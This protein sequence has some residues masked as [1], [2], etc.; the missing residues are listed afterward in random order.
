M[1][2]TLLLALCALAVL[3]GAL[4]VFP[5]ASRADL[6]IM[7]L[8][9]VFND[10]DRTFDMTLA[11]S[12]DKTNTYRIEWSFNKMREDGTYE[13]LETPLN[14]EFDFTKNVV[15]SPRQVTIAPS[16]RQS[17]RLSLR[18]PAELPEGEYRAHLTFRRLADSGRNNRKPDQGVAIAIGVNIGFSVPVIVRVG[19][20]DAQASISDI[21]LL[22]PA[23]PGQNNRISL[24]LNRTGKHSITGR[25]I[26]FWTPPGGQEE[27]IGI[28][29]NLNVFTEISRRN[30]Q[31]VLTNTKP[32]T[33]GTLRVIYEGIDSAAS[34]TPKPRCRSSKTP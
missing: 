1:T 21:Q 19:A 30:I 11:N 26:V 25:V 22:P 10:R 28:L 16:N 6:T 33:G 20:Y 5:A 9:V 15:F 27:Q 34:N 31:I 3:T 14:P 13:K 17:V 32:L 12:S 2:R 8:R 7:P 24:N 18:R 4:L 23:Q 29:N